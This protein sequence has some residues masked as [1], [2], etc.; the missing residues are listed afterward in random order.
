M[1]IDGRIV[2]NK[3]MVIP[4]GTGETVV[5]VTDLAPGIYYYQLN[6]LG[7]SYSGKFVK[8]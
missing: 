6:T 7:R 1:S 3:H 5:M 4:G 8:Q 2:Y